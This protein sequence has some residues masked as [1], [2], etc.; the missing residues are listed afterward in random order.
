MVLNGLKIANVPNCSKYPNC[1][2]WFALRLCFT[3]IYKKRG[4]TI[5]LC[6]DQASWYQDIFLGSGQNAT[7]QAEEGAH[8]ILRNYILF[9]C[10]Y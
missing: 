3:K 10:Y 5:A 9:K 1:V 4:Q 6:Q 8:S 2:S 7:T